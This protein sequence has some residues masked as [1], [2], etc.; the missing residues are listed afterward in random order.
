MPMLPSTERAG[1]GRPRLMG[2][3]VRVAG[4]RHGWRPR[5]P[6]RHGE[7]Q[8]GGAESAWAPGTVANS[9]APRAI[10]VIAFIRV[11]P[12][13]LCELKTS[14]RGHPPM[15]VAR[16]RLARRWMSREDRR[17]SRRS[18]DRALGG[19]SRL[20][21]PGLGRPAAGTA[22]A[23]YCHALARWPVRAAD[24]GSAVSGS[25]TPAPAR[26]RSAMPSA[27]VLGRIPGH[28]APCR[29]AA[30]SRSAAGASPESSASVAGGGEP[31]RGGRVAVGPPVGGRPVPGRA[32]LGSW[33]RHHPGRVIAPSHCAGAAVRPARERA[34]LG[35]RLAVRGISSAAVMIA[36]T[37]STGLG[38][39]RPRGVRSR[40][41][42]ARARPRASAQR[43]R[44][45]SAPPGV[46]A[47]LRRGSGEDRRE[48]LPRPLQLA[49]VGELLVQRVAQLDEELDVEGR[50]AQPLD[51]QRPGGPV[52]RR[53]PL[54]QPVAEH[55][56]HHR[57]QA[58][59]LV[60]ATGGTVQETRRK[61]NWSGTAGRWRRSTIWRRRAPDPAPQPAG[62]A[63]GVD[64]HRRTRPAG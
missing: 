8:L 3:A 48:L 37:G 27:E 34:D 5:R 56:L 33:T 21:Y 17:R 38:A 44:W 18:R 25:A 4:E 9:S 41:S 64:Q 26:S 23:A 55:G 58:H 53:V 16:R 32:R 47:R 1:A 14:R 42:P 30:G 15:G 45:I 39:G 59:P 6:A 10:T 19:R 31:G 60:G 35:E 20:L 24:S 28:G 57:A 22:R 13:R 49:R 62:Q 46:R 61:S 36:A 50:V 40:S 29:A 63:G 52:R 7:R 51:R 12:D 54:L 43:T 11:P 2:A